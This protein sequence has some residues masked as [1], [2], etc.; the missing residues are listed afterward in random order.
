MY[1]SKICR[2]NSSF[3]KNRTRIKST[4]HENQNMFLNISHLILLI[5][6]TFSDKIVEKIETDILYSINF[7]ESLPVC[8]TMWKNILEQ[9]KP[10]MI[11]WGMRIACWLPKATTTCSGCV[12]LFA[13]PLQ[14]WLH[15]RTSLLL[16]STLP[17]FFSHIGNTYSR[18][19]G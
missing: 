16:Y 10:E 9:R 14:Q 6:K 19:V 2:E 15:E 3:I 1:F 5:M 13:L 18:L 11:I 8:K 17:V 4:L 12:T 7:F